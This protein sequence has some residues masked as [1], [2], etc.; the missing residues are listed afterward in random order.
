MADF[1]GLN[2]QQAIAANVPYKNIATAGNPAETFLN[3]WA[4]TTNM[5]MKQ[6]E[7]Q[8]R[9]A[10]LALKNADLEHD[11]RMAEAKFGL[12]MMNSEFDHNM[13]EKL[14]GITAERTQNAYEYN[15]GKLDLANQKLSQ[16]ADGKA[17]ILRVQ[18]Q[19]YTEGL[20]PGDVGYRPRFNQLMEGIANDIPNAVFKST[21]AQAYKEDDDAIK[22]KST[23]VLQDEKDF[24]NDIGRKFYGGNTLM[25]NMDVILHPEKLP[26]ETTG[27]GPWEKT[28]GNKVIPDPATGE[29]KAYS[30]SDLNAMKQRWQDIQQRKANLPGRS[31]FPKSVPVDASGNP[32]K[33]Q[34]VPG[35][36]YDVPGR[37]IMRWTG[38]GLVPP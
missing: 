9:M 27:W 29:K 21:M 19:L 36:K 33:T 25:Q 10:Q 3:A 17:G 35:D 24:R 28:T 7:F 30:M 13:K 31:D 1:S 2:Q 20:K 22:N 11:N 4:L 37:G 34:M 12:A 15:M 5:K 18:N 38:T 8:G 16:A 6:Q 26:D 32:D 14:A 23:T